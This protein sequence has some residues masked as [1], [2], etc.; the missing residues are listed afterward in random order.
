MKGASR[1]WTTTEETYATKVFD[2]GSQGL[3]E[4]I[5]GIDNI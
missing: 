1:G 2:G 3:A 4:E 5:A